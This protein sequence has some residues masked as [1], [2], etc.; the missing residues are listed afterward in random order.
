MPCDHLFRAVPTDSGICCAF[1]MAD[2]LRNSSYARLL[3]SMQTGEERQ[4]TNTK[5]ENKKAQV[6]RSK[7]LKV[8]LD[9]QYNTKSFG[10]VESD[11][12]AMKV[13]SQS[14]SQSQSW[15]LY[16]SRIRKSRDQT[17]YWGFHA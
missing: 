11:S 14:D 3:A 1:N 16:V 10:T 15:E 6:G 2:T 8:L 13:M 9:Q 4:E 5:K 7:G 17:N 12:K